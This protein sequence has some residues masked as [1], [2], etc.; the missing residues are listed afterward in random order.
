MRRGTSSSFAHCLLATLVVTGGFA[1]GDDGTGSDDGGADAGAPD[2]GRDATRNDAAWPD[3]G[4]AGDRRDRDGGVYWRIYDIVEHCRRLC[5]DAAMLR[6]CAA[7]CI[8]T[9]TGH[10]M[11][12]PCADCF[13][14]VAECTVEI[15]CSD[16][17]DEGWAAE[18]CYGCRRGPSRNCGQEFRACAG[19]AEFCS[20]LDVEGPEACLNDADM[21]AIAR[22]YYLDAGILDGG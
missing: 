22:R 19:I 18:E 7:D 2:T 13:A 16:P 12:E 15:G 9:E 17:C 11:S 20:A 14:G 6:S 21:S 4:D 10:L 8:R 3:A 1:C 5:E